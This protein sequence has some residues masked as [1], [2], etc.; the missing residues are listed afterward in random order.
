M[1]HKLGW[2][3]D[4][5]DKRDYLYKVSAV[6]IPT[7]FVLPN[8]PSIRDQG[9]VGS[10]VGHGIGA[11][12]TGWAMSQKM[13]TEWFSPT[14][15]Y[16]GARFIEGSLAQDIGAYPKD[17]LNWIVN[18]GCLLEHFW[19]YNP[20][21]VDTAV[22][23]SKFN[24]EAL[25]FPVVSYYRITGGVN[26][27]C[28]AIANGYYVSIGTPWYDTWMN[29]PSTGILPVVTIKNVVLGGHETCLFGY[30]QTTK[31][32]NGMNSWGVGWG[33][34]GFYQM[35][36]QAF[37]VFGYRGGYDAHYITVKWATVPTPTPVAATRIQINKSKDGGPWELVTEFEMK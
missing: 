22:P 1:I 8:V 3:K 31:L 35:P 26:A 25:K 27:I 9:N 16:N 36:F 28:D 34:K 29:V 14:W 21:A 7:V 2:K 15:I 37:D 20:N 24:T 6:K 30:N 19:P 23:P 10:C 32:F 4:K 12:L 11:N 5:F 33:N 18:K 17:A 13:F